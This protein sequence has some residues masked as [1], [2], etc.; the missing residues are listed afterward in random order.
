MGADR[1]GERAVVHAVFAAFTALVLIKPPAGAS[2]VLLGALAVA[3]WGFATRGRGSRLIAMGI[4]VTSWFAGAWTGWIALI[5]SWT[6]RRRLFRQPGPTSSPAAPERTDDTAGIQRRR[7]PRT[8]AQVLAEWPPNARDVFAAARAEHGDGYVDVVMNDLRP[9]VRHYAIQE[10]GRLRETRAVNT[11]LALLHDEDFYTYHYAPVALARIGTDEAR[12]GL[13]EGF[14]RAWTAHT[15]LSSPI[16]T[17]EER[18]ALTHEAR[19][20]HE[21]AEALVIVGPAAIGPLMVALRDGSEEVVTSSS[22]PLGAL[23]AVEAV[24]LMLNRLTENNN[25]MKGEVREAIRRIGPRAIPA[26][27]ENQQASPAARLLAA[28]MLRSLQGIPPP[29]TED[30]PDPPP[31]RTYENRSRDPGGD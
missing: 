14:R 2:R 4:V 1:P 20:F 11:L 23:G 29:G 21:I 12:E 9:Y 22:P 13:F 30:P 16:E 10:F 19:G 28:Q 26:L 18:T 31:V 6:V 5:L 3:A 7:T 24:P 8:P 15:R 17:S 25:A 27:V